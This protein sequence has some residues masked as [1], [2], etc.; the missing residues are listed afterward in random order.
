MV[1]L[2]LLR[3]FRFWRYCAG[4]TWVLTHK[5]VRYGYIRLEFT[6]HRKR[7]YNSLSGSQPAISITEKNPYWFWNKGKPR[8][9]RSRRAVSSA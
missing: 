9:S 2:Y 7:V 8:S 3:T 1:I 6:W 5:A 4:G